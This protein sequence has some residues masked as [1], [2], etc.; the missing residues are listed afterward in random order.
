VQPNITQWLSWAL[1]CYTVGPQV[2]GLAQCRNLINTVINVKRTQT[3]TND[4]LLQ[5][6]IYKFHHMRPDSPRDFGAI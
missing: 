1:S 6:N 5:V 4:K 2:L 3:L